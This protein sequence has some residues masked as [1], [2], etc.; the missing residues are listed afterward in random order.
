MSPA[1][2]HRLF[3]ILAVF[4]SAVLLAWM[5]TDFG[6]VMPAHAQ[7]LWV[8]LATVWFFWPVILLLHVG[9]SPARV[10]IPLTAAVLIGNP[11]MRIYNATARP[12]FRLPIWCDLAPPSAAKY[13][14]AYLD[15][16]RDAERDLREGKLS[17]ETFGF[18]AWLITQ[19]LRERYQVEARLVAGC[20]VDEAI[21]G[22]AR[23]YNLVAAAEIRK[24]VGHDILKERMAQPRYELLQVERADLPLG[25][26]ADL[27]PR[28]AYQHR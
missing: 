18:G 2:R 22:H 26:P 27:Q 24:R 13:Y 16:R 28:L 10:L 11:S 9:R 21:L 15:A 23:G 5:R 17:L 1:A 14:L 3:G 6:W 25:E 12:A 7:L 8:G 20:M 19:P 4:H